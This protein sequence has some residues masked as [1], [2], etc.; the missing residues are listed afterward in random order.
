MLNV[1]VNF[2]NEK[3]KD[4]EFLRNLA[5]DKIQ[6]LA[7]MEKYEKIKTVTVKDKKVRYFTVL[8]A[9]AEMV[10]SAVEPDFE[11]SQAQINAYIWLNANK[12]IGYCKETKNINIKGTLVRTSNKVIL[13]QPLYDSL[14]LKKANKSY[15]KLSV[16]VKECLEKEF[17]DVIKSHKK[18]TLTVTLSQYIAIN[19]ENITFDVAK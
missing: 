10:K 1:G 3:K 9:I 5:K 14:K 11:K 19:G 4:V 17:Y 7:I 15:R 6:L 8:R 12:T 2:A 16:V 18:R 13:N